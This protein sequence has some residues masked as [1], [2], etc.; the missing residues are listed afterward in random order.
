MRRALVLAAIGLALWGGA[1]SAQETAPPVMAALLT[2]DEE[3]LF[4]SSLFGQALIKRN[5]ADGQT[6][7]A[8]N[9][10]IE[11]DLEQEEKDLTARRATMPREEFAPLAAAF[12]SKVEG[13]RAAQAAKERDLNRQ[14]EAERLRFLEAVRPVLAEIMKARG[15]V[16][17]IDK[18][19]VFVGFENVDVTA[20]AIAQLDKAFE[21]GT[22]VLQ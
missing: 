14:F 7:V 11:A 19:A 22:L 3:R 2:L 5:E 13:I 9:R 18:R 20:D 1:G 10:R 16:A 8:E 21:D 12:D 4:A 17:I 15:A 6:L